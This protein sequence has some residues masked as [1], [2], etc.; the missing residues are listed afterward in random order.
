VKKSLYLNID[1]N[2]VTTP[3]LQ[4]VVKNG[5]LSKE[6]FYPFVDQYLGGQ[7]TD[8]LFDT[9]CQYS[10]TPS[11]VFTD[12]YAKSQQTEENGIPVAYDATQSNPYCDFTYAKV[13]HDNRI[14]VYGIW[15]ERCMEVGLHP[16]LSVRM[17]DSHCPDEKTCFLR[18]DFFY[19]ANQKGWTVGEE[20][21]Y[22]RYC[23]NYAVPE[24]REKMLAYIDEQVT[25]YDVY[26]IELD[27]MREMV[28]FDYFHDNGCVE[29]MNAFMR[30]VRKIVNKAGERW[31]H[32]IKILARLMRDIEQNRVFGFDGITWAKEGLIDILS[33]SP[34]WRSCD[35]DMPVSDWRRLLPDN[36]E[37]VAGI[38]TLMLHPGGGSHADH[39]T[40]RGYAAAF[41]SEGADGIYLYNYFSNPFKPNP[42]SRKVLTCSQ[43]NALPRRHVV[44]YQDIV[45]L[46]MTAWNPLGSTFTGNQCFSVLTGDV[47]EHAKATLILGVDP[48]KCCLENAEV[49]INGFVCNG[50]APVITYG[51]SETTFQSVEN[52][53]I[54]EGVVTYGADIPCKLPMYRQNIVIRS[55]RPFTLQ[56]LEIRLE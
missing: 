49:S 56:Y 4:Q 15:L 37:L 32:P 17:N 52:G 54:G 35:S 8:L 48:Q 27:F 45:P 30:A 53:Y 22:F 36:V 14:D 41:L 1:I 25:R 20:Y 21:G 26:G 34:R 39:E 16:W 5:D 43:K 7:L 19:E 2:T 33:I 47:P 24:V 29:T 11:K 31:G 38:E 46:G 50:F 51:H 18:S 10:A 6:N 44:T 28:C 3:F 55:E 12:A 42:R 13:F 23:W 40:V 9:F